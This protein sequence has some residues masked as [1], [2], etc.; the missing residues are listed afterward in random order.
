MNTMPTYRQGRRVF[1]PGMKRK[2]PCDRLL[3][4]IGVIL[5]V[6][7]PPIA[8]M[9]NENRR[10]EINASL[11]ETLDQG[12]TE[13]PFD[14]VQKKNEQEDQT[15]L[16]KGD[17]VHGTPTYI[18]STTADLDMGIKVADS[19]TL[20]RKTEYCQWEELQRESCETCTRTE[21]NSD[22]STTTESYD[23]NCVTSYDYIKS[24]KPYRVNS[25]LFDQPAAHHNPQ[26]DP[27][28]AKTF[29]SKDAVMEFSMDGDRHPHHEQNQQRENNK[30]IPNQEEKQQYESSTTLST[31]T[32][33]IVP[34]MFR[35]QIRGARSRIIKWQKGGI[36]PTPSFFTRW[37]P[38][39]SRYEDT[40]DLFHHQANSKAAREFNFVYVGDGY[41]FSPYEAQDRYSD[42]FKYFMQYVEG[43]LF[44]WQ[45][46]DLMPSCQAG[47]IRVQYSVQDPKYVSILGQVG[48]KPNVKTKAEKD[49]ME[50]TVKPFVAKNDK[51]VGLVHEGFRT[52]LEMI[53]SEDKDSFYKACFFRVLLLLWSIG[54]SRVIGKFFGRDVSKAN[55]PTQ[56]AFALSLWCGLTGCTW[57]YVWKSNSVDC[58]S[59]LVASIAFGT[60]VYSDPPP[61]ISE[62]NG[63]NSGADRK[64]K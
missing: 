63:A 58:V 60:L 64:E 41:F 32:A 54:I 1:T 23:C 17:L 20:H 53:V 39:R 14:I 13:I 9:M 46:G 29:V 34:E 6:S 48:N 19:L 15:T 52:A 44:D 10:H 43:S 2:S 47:D 36:P 50:V 8:F 40:A 31:L 16:K 42:L 12:I 45:I 30:D 55:I 5:L 18:Q 49:V 38:D 59:L 25:F 57:I 21:R 37:I 51:S 56:L 4:V 22:G 27:M 7:L 62:K 24:W 33:K 61:I 3:S 11:S 35:N 26:R 28:P